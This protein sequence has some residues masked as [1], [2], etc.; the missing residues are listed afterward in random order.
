MS[1][2]NMN[3]E[4]SKYALECVERVIKNE[5]DYN[6]Y[7]KPNPKSV[8]KKSYKTL[9]KKMSTLIQKNGFINTIVFLMSKANEKNYKNGEKIVRNND[10]LKKIHSKQH[11]NLILQD[12]L[13]WHKE[14]P[15]I[16]L[17]LQNLSEN[18]D[19]NTKK[20]QEYIKFLYDLNS[21][22]YR[23]ITKEMMTLFGWIKRFA[24]AMIESEDKTSENNGGD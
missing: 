6:D 1:L 2:K 23:L 8:D 19:F 4:V 7:N 5:N 24:D 11:Y 3:L 22:E 20:V 9:V 15:K 17:E 16:E 12:I 18:Y 10:E 21:Q 13:N 14:N